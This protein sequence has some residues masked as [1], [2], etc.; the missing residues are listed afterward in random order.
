MK[1]MNYHHLRYFREVARQGHLGRA[2]E[3]LNVSQS[4]LSIQ[5]KQ[6][7]DRMGHAFFD[8]VGRG[9]VLTEAGRIA[10]DHADRIAR[11][12]HLRR[13]AEIRQHGLPHAG[14]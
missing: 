12:E 9:L 11:P 3:L 2:A 8:R 1:Q 5:I 6:L 4:A 10:L 13:G 14:P 7:E